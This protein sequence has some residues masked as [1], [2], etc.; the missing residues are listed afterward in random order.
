MHKLISGL[1]VAGF[2]LAGSAAS[3]C[4]ETARPQDKFDPRLEVPTVWKMMGVLNLDKPTAEK[5]IEIR[6]KFI[7]ER[8]ALQKETAQ[9]FQKLRQLLREDSSKATDD[10]LA[11]VLQSISDKRLKIQV[12]F[13]EY[14][15][16]VS[17]ILSIRQ[18]AELVLLLKDFHKEIRPILQRPGPPGLPHD[19]RIMI[20]PPSPTRGWMR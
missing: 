13:D 20:L 8:K 2:L 9:D 14:Y 12:L 6:R 3:F 7:V 17:K 10:E 11:G 15:N 1:I 4:S 16:E 18:R 5:V 19:K